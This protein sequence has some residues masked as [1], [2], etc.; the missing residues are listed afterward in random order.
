MMS[1]VSNAGPAPSIG[2]ISYWG[3]DTALYDQIPKHS[4]ALINPD[5]GI[6][7]SDGQTETLVPDLDQYQAIV[8]R[9]TQRGVQM[10]GYV[11]TGYF[12]H[13]CN[14]GGQCQLWSRI[15]AEVAAAARL[16]GQEQPLASRTL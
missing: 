15:D 2:V 10:L 13:S 11:E 1:I 4:V 8:T 3:T 9:E 16:Q 5:N 7:V 12:D 14:V 6:F